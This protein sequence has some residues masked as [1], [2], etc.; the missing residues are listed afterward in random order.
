MT[1]PGKGELFNGGYMRSIHIKLPL[2]VLGIP[3]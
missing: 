2:Q 1:L 3:S